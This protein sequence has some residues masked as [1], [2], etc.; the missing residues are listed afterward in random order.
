MR[1]RQCLNTHTHTQHKLLFLKLGILFKHV[2]YCLKVQGCDR[3]WNESLLLT[4]AVFGRWECVQETGLK[5]VI[6]FEIL[7]FDALAAQKQ[8][9][10][11]LKRGSVGGCDL[12]WPQRLPQWEYDPQTHSQT[13]NPRHLSL[14]LFHTAASS[15][16]FLKTN[17]SL[18]CLQCSGGQ[19]KHTVQVCVCVWLKRT[20]ETLS[21][22]CAGRTD[23]SLCQITLRE[24]K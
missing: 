10:S 15:P 18:M 24:I 23:S 19:R 3:F 7:F 13:L 12:L 1:C 17:H 20:M 16:K 21:Y 11:A 22:D 14:S 9:T 5:T 8:H 2:H 4:K 6:I